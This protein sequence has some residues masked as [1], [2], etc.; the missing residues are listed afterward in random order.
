MDLTEIL[1]DYIYIYIYIIIMDCGNMVE[2]SLQ[3][4]IGLN[5]K[6][7]LEAADTIKVS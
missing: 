6:R 2:I 1:Y 5:A 3:I 4:T 7:K